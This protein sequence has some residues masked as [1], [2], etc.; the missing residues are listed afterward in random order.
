MV[1]V[2][3]HIIVYGNCYEVRCQNSQSHYNK[4]EGISIHN[5]IFGKCKSILLCGSEIHIVTL[6]KKSFINF[7]NDG[8][9]LS[10]IQV[11]QKRGIRNHKCS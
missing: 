8:P 4:T 2:T 1:L 3:D 5:I 7:V 9:T 10:Y 11:R 6:K